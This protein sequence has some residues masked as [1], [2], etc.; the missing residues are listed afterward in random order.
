MKKAYQVILKTNA[1]KDLDDIPVDILPKMNKVFLE[2][3]KDPRPPGVKKLDGPVYR[4][5]VGQ[6]RIIYS[7]FDKNGEVVIFRIRRR[8]EKTYKTL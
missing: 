7:I 5:R 8:N 2:M 3:A 1:S 6:W 4:I